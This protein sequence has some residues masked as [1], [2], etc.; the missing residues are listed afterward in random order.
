MKTIIKA[1]CIF[2]LFILILLS[3]IQALSPRE[4]VLQLLKEY[5]PTGYYIVDQ[6]EKTPEET[7]FKYMKWKTKKDDFMEFVKGSTIEDHLAAI[8]IV[9]HETCH[10][11]SA[12]MAYQLSEERLGQAAPGYNAYYIGNNTNILVKRTPVFNTG[13]IAA[14]IPEHLR[15][16]RFKLYV[17]PESD[18][19]SKSIG[20][21]YFGIYGLLDEFNAYYHGNKAAFDFYPYYRDQMKTARTKWHD[22]LWGVNCSFAANMEF[23]F[24]ILKYLQYAKTN[25]PEI[26]RGIIGNKDFKKAFW[27]INKNHEELTT[28]YFRLKEEI[29][30][31]FRKEG[32]MVSEDQKYYYIGKAPH[33]VGTRNHLEA[34]YL[35]Q[36]ELE[37][38]EYQLLLGNLRTAL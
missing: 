29:Y 37:K 30:D 20:S 13:E 38:E 16:F 26:Y 27:A 34:F 4:T 6:Y 28:E 3:P 36:T 8:N 12:L 17:S 32:F 5:S 10:T 2:V 21:K 14:S 15:T 19:G 31:L 35:L 24:F 33:S 7:E 25:Y 1:L 18:G 23:K 9:V 11:Y 22:Y